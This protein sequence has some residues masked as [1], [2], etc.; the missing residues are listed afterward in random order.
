M[1]ISP[2][3]RKALE[4]AGYKISR[5]GSAVLDKNGATV[6]SYNENGGISSGSGKVSA[7][8]KAKDAPAK[9]PAKP[10]AKAPAK[11]K[12][13]EAPVAKDPTKGYRKGDVTT[14]KLDSPKPRTTPSQKSDVQV[15]P[16]ADAPYPKPK[17]EKSTPGAALGKAVMNTLRGRGPATPKGVR[18]QKEAQHKKR[19][20]AYKKQQAQRNTRAQ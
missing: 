9:A 19:M 18:A 4:A 3:K 20:D 14:T 6:A 1:K 13:K 8:L 10:A 11:P 16:R 5:S 12:A 7:I 17:K 2:E 15:P